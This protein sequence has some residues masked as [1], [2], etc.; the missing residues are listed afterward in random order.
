MR[1]MIVMDTNFQLRL[2]VERELEMGEVVASTP[3][4]LPM[5]KEAY[6]ALLLVK[7]TKGAVFLNAHLP[8]R[9]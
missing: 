7:R 3:A 6:K 2:I 5:T 9:L 1:Y 4:D 8:L